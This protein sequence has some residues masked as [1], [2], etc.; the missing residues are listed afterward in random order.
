MDELDHWRLCDE[1]SVIDAA[2]LIAGLDPATTWIHDNAFDRDHPVYTAARTALKNAVRS[3]RLKANI[4]HE[5]WPRGFNEDLSEDEYTQN[6][7]GRQ[8]FF[9]AEP[10]WQTTTILVDDLRTWLS[11]RGFKS[12]FFFP[13]GAEEKPGYLSK[14]NQFYANKLAAAMQAWNAVSE[15]SALIK[16]KTPKQAIEKWL[17]EHASEYGL[18]KDD[19]SPNEQG[20]DEVAKVANWKPGG[21]VAKTPGN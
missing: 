7:E 1:L 20:I 14:E 18:T 11:I 12:G 5:S 17:R 15:N 8:Y 2:L 19:G 10:D 16:G 9:K 21:G 13:L 6:I 3:R 4:R